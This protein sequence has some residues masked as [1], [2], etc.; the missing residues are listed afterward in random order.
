L[1]T[2]DPV[3]LPLVVNG[4]VAP[5]H[6][7]VGSGSLPHGLSLSFPS[8][9]TAGTVITGTPDTVAQAVNFTMQVTDSSGGSGSQGYTVS[10]LLGGDSM[11]FSPS[12]LNF[13]PQLL[14]TPST[15]ETVTVTNAILSPITISGVAIA[16]TD[17]SEF[18]ENTTCN[19][20]LAAGASCTIGVV[21]TPAQVGQRGASITI[22]DDT[23]GSPHSV[24]LGGIGIVSGPNA[25]W[26]A[27]S[28]PFGSVSVGDTSLAQS[29]N[30]INYGTLPLDI[31]S[32]TA[33]PDFSETDNCT[34]PLA[35]EASCTVN[36]TFSPSATGNINGT[37]SVAYS[38]AG[39][40]QSTSLT[41]SGVAGKCQSK[42][43]GCS[44]VSRCCPGL[45][46]TNAGPT[47]GVCQ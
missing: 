7:T 45:Q 5:Y 20:T 32:I 22:T 38:G 15:Q 33:S 2:G 12:P 13:A 34:A 43:M 18:G 29:V 39:S 26:S 28:V 17:S 6:W 40:P 36:V 14:A 35:P 8:P 3:Q 47:G 21:F 9:D 46:C 27:T 23:Q 24:S 10:V 4:G 25:T 37:L 11:T 19:S 41:G 30:L 16:G 42:G 1:S 31:T 44:V